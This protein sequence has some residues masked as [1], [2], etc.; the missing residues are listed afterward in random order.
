MI[1]FLKLVANTFVAREEPL[2][3]ITFVFPNRRSGVFFSKYLAENFE[4]KSFVLPEIIT[5]SEFIS[6]YTKTI[7]ASRMEQLFALYSVYKKV[8]SK[9]SDPNKAFNFDQFIYWGDMILSDF[10]DVDR[11]MVNAK[12]LFA[13]VKNYKEIASNFLEAEHLQVIRDFWGED[14]FESDNG[15]LWKDTDS[16]AKKGFAKLWEM[17][18]EIYDGFNDLLEKKGLS[19]SGKTYR[20]A[21]EKM[22]NAKVEDFNFSK[23]VFVGFSTLSA[24][25]LKIF[26]SFQKL[27]L[28]EFYWDF[29]SPAFSVSENKGK[30]FVSEYIKRFPSPEDFKEAPI[31]E[32]PNIQIMSVPSGSGQAKVV[33]KIIS[34]LKPE[35]R[36]ETKD[37]DTAIVL[38]EEIY[39]NSVLFSLPETIKKP[40]ITMGYPL[41]NTSIASL[42]SML[43]TLHSRKRII[44]GEVCYYYEDLEALLSHPYIK[45][46]CKD[47]IDD[48]KKQIINMKYFFVPQSVVSKIFN[49]DKDKDKDEDEDED[50]G[51]GSVF[52]GTP[53]DKPEEIIDYIDGI[54][55]LVKKP[56][57]KSQ[58]N[59]NENEKE[60]D[61]P[62]K[63]ELSFICQYENSL[64]QMKT[65][66]GAYGENIETMKAKTFFMLMERLLAGSNI[67]FQGEP[68][69]GLQIMGVLETRL[70]DFENVF[71]LSMNERI[72]PSKHFTK[73]FIPM[74]LR[75][76]YGMSTYEYQESM[77]T[78][79]FYRMISRAKNV[80][81]L[82]DSRTQGISSGEQSRYIYQLQRLY[83]VGKCKKI[84]WQYNVELPEER[85]I[86]IKKD[87]RILEK[88]NK[89]LQ[90]GSKKNFSAS[91]LS[92]Y[93]NCPLQWYLQYIEGLSEEDEISEFIDAST[94]GTIVH[95]TLQ[96]I[97]DSIT[98]NS[99]GERLVQKKFLDDL[100]DSKV[101]LEKFVVK[102]VNEHYNKRQKTDCWKD[103]QGDSILIFKTVFYYV[104]SVLKYDSRLAP[105]TYLASEYGNVIRWNLGKDTDRIVNFKF[106]ID[107]IDRLHS[108]DGDIVRII[109]YKTGGDR[110]EIANVDEM[111]QD[112]SEQKKRA[113]AIAQLML[114]CHAYEECNGGKPMKL[115][116]LIYQIRKINEYAEKQFSLNVCKNEV[117]DFRE[118]DDGFTVTAEDG[119]TISFMDVIKNYLA[120]IFDKDVPFRQ[121]PKEDNCVYCPFKDIC[122]R[123]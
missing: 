50:E 72:F 22:E 29:N 20:M 117:N 33:G 62:D 58:E 84:N 123:K 9:I 7:E 83:N 80:Y 8:A 18:L 101:N 32:M 95:E 35:G 69:S 21:A 105:F 98:P 93:I 59:E 110:V 90:E 37:I 60:L 19:Y 5:I 104:K 27:Q 92:T 100:L 81:L 88:M 108:T 6:D 26:E 23:I 77:F 82:Y 51:M 86:E 40:N 66:I 114:Y 12:S 17:L 47:K 3:E 68:L 10:N 63:L 14:R 75:K 38:P 85:V 4:N 30:K 119:Q 79:Y 76:G 67:A 113:H 2:D 65:A 71:I 64:N 49:L 34:E 91:M 109:D 122:G 39:L 96:N 107:R 41:R 106:K 53:L 70:L 74:S 89:Y 25:E 111:F 16:D 78:Y 46:I 55:D 116:P 87:V 48:L 42:M 112:V 11:Y 120:E 24:S 15:H 97:Y 99:K 56:F 31:T 73:S 118:I 1:P 28:G 36:D 54:I 43:S 121:T 115:K 61:N 94:L 57:E 45:S 103:L 44:N 102:S 52:T 13:N